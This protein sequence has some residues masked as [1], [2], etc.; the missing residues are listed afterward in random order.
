MCRQEINTGSDIALHE[1]VLSIPSYT[2]IHIF[3]F[4]RGTILTNLVK[5]S[6]FE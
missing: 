2:E 5:F 1:I 6:E 4:C 3:K